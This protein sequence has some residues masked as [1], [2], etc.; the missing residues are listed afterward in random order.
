[1]TV[2]T[3]FVFSLECELG[4]FF[5]VLI[6]LISLSLCLQCELGFGCTEMVEFPYFLSEA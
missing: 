4:F 2:S 3:F 5:F 1:V 6:W